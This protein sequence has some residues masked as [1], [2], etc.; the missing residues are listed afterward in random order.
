MRVVSW[1]PV[2]AELMERAVTHAS[3]VSGKS[4]PPVAYR[5]RGLPKRHQ[6]KVRLLLIG[7]SAISEA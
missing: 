4:F 6:T 2:D 7:L 3:V 1:K 5:E